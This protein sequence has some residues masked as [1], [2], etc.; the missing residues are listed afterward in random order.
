MN[1]KIFVTSKFIC[2]C[3]SS[4]RLEIY[5]QP[6]CRL[7]GGSPVLVC[8]FFYLMLPFNWFV[9]LLSK[10]IFTIIEN[11]QTIVLFDLI[12]QPGLQTIIKT[13]SAIHL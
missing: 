11:Q 8:F 9:L 1:Y 7:I 4:Q 6:Q 12:S 3:S 2:F 13:W 10:R 5:F